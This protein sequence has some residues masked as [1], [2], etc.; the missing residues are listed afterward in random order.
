MIVH[1]SFSPK[2]ERYSFVLELS[3]RVTSDST[4][5]SE[6]HFV[7]QIKLLAG[8]NKAW[9]KKIYGGDKKT[10]DRC[11]GSGGARPEDPHRRA[12]HEI[13]I[14]QESRAWYL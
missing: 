13:P 9:P 7:K 1:F 14:D 11:M 10:R 6:G 8:I 3:T 5:R 2:T 4:L 12:P